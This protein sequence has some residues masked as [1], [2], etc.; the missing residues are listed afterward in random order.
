MSTN[1]WVINYIPQEKERF[2][3]NLTVSK[4]EIR[5]VSF[6]ESSNK[7]IVKAIFTETASFAASGGHAMYRY[8]NDKEAVV[9]L[10]A[11]EIDKV[12]AT[13]KGLFKRA[14]I[15]MKNGDSFVFDY[16]LLSVNKLVESIKAI[17]PR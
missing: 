17:I 5:F 4:E 11:K 2:T 14:V 3:G 1:K 16:G 9:A 12:E 15:I 8:S 6:Y 7:T 10:P 13:K